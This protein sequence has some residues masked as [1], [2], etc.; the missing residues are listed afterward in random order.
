MFKAHQI[1]T[2]RLVWVLHYMAVRPVNKGSPVHTKTE[3]S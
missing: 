1:R 3:E 2:L